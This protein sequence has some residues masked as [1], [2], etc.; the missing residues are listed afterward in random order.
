MDGVGSAA[1]FCHPFGIAIDQQT[2]NLFA[3]DMYN[4]RIRKI[5]PQGM[6]ISLL[7]PFHNTNINTKE[8]SRHSLDQNLALQMEKAKKR[9]LIALIGS[10]LMRVQSHYLFVTVTR[11]G[12]CYSMVCNSCLAFSTLSPFVF[13][14]SL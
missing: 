7:F 2:G 12:G 6:Y 9:S 14:S 11:S 13:I 5:T 1:S 3:T 8:R 10:A 4:H